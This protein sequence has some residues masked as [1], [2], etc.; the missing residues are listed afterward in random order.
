MQHLKVMLFRGVILPAFSL[1]LAG[2]AVG[3]G[4]N[5]PLSANRIED[6]INRTERQAQENHRDTERS[7]DNKGDVFTNRGE[8]VNDNIQVESKTALCV[9]IEEIEISG[10]DDIDADPEFVD[11][12]KG[13]CLNGKD[14][15]DLVKRLN[16]FFQDEGYP[17]SRVYIPQQSLADGKLDLLLRPGT[18]AGFAF[19]GDEELVDDSR[20]SS[21]FPLSEGD[22]IKLRDLEQGLE[23]FSAP[24]SQE[25][26]LK[27]LPA[28]EVGESIISLDEK[29]T[30]PVRV[31]LNTDNTG[32]KFIGKMNGSLDIG[33][34]NVIGMN[35]TVAVGMT[36]T[37]PMG[38]KGTAESYS[39]STFIPYGYWSAN[40]NAGYQ[41]YIAPL[42]GINQ[43]YNLS[44]YGTR[45]GGS[46]SNLVWRGQSTKVSVMAHLTAARSRNFIN[47]EEIVTQRR[48]TASYGISANIRQNIQQAVLSASLGYKNGVLAFG[49]RKPIGDSYNPRFQAL[50]GDISL[51]TPLLLD[52]LVYRTSVS[53]QLS[54]NRLPNSEQFFVGGRSTVRGFREDFLYGDSGLLFRNDLEY[55]IFKNDWLTGSVNIGVDYAV[56]D[57][58]KNFPYSQNKIAGV[59]GTGRVQLFDSISAEMGYEYAA[60]RPEEFTDNKDVFFLGIN[61]DAIRASS[62]MSDLVRGWFGGK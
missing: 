44:G 30:Y 14:I 54:N 2:E 38:S 23:N 58:P 33:V 43:K 46:F 49:A 42:Q 4:V 50:T 29:R 57:P 48:Y 5:I 6:N 1:F 20:I 28:K 52:G 36:R 55:E 19:S 21:A 53:G 40:L 11:S 59:S 27:L 60:S 7:T 9:N 8:T 32:S 45:L 39:V 61:V 51:E 34:D 26:K 17:T 25:V 24:P 31:S 41:R 3:Q 22:I 10:G 47:E 62:E 12:Y 35:D 15:K 37:L 18:L 16:I 13:K 56:V